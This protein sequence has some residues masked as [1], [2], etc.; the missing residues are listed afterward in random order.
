MAFD[1]TMNISGMGYQPAQSNRIALSSPTMLVVAMYY[2]Y[3]TYIHIY[4]LMKR[5]IYNLS[6]SHILNMNV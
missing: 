5:H 1:T 6:A 2:I 4:T 3:F